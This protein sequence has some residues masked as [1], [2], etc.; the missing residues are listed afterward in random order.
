MI[1][2]QMVIYQTR[3]L[4]KNIFSETLSCIMQKNELSK[5]RTQYGLSGARHQAY[6]ALLRSHAAVTAQVTA[7][8]Q[9]EDAL[10]LDWYDVLLAL[11][12]AP[13]GRLRV[14]ELACHVTHSRSGLTRLVDKLEEAGMVQRHLNPVDRRSFEIVLKP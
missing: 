11:E 4:R 7:L 12:Y 9:S 6:A 2:Y 1:Y 3:Y 5:W 10:P 13:E 8:T 14:G